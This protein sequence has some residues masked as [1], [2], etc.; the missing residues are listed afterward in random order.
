[1]RQIV[2]AAVF[3]LVFGTVSIAQTTPGTQ[4]PDTNPSTQPQTTPSQSSDM[5]KMG[6]TK[7]EK[8]LKGCLKSSGGSYT[9]EQKGGKDVALSSSQDLSAH[10]GHMVTVHGSY[11]GGSSSASGAASSSATS[12]TG[13]DTFTVTK[14]DMVS[15]SCGMDK[16]K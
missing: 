14:V 16:S 2:I 9:L 5:S 11:A 8:K 4:S 12:S 1:V 3:A 15:D 6:D 10:V 13:G 7:G